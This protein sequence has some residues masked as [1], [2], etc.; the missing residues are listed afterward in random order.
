MSICGPHEVT[1]KAT[2]YLTSQNELSDTIEGRLTPYNSRL[3]PKTMTPP[4]LSLNVTHRVAF[5]KGNNEQTLGVCARVCAR[6][7]ACVC[8]CVCV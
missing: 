1:R 3:S 8:V 4:P 7:C 5:T 6:V 2:C